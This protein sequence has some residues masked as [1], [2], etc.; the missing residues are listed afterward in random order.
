VG[1]GDPFDFVGEDG[2]DV[3]V[4]CI[5]GFTG[6]PYEMRYLS[7][8]LARTG[9]TV[10]GILLPG[11]GT[12]VDDLE[13]TRWE[14]WAGAVEREVDAMSKRCRRVALVGQSLGGLLALHSASRRPDLAAVA[15]LAAPLWLD[16][17]SGRVARWLTGPLGSRIRRI[18]KFGG[19]DVRDRVARAENPS[20]PS[21]PV[22]ALGELLAFMPIVEAALPQIVAPVLVLHARRDHTAP[23]G[24]AA[25]IIARAIRARARH[26]RILDRSFHLIAIDVERDLV[27]EEVI[28]FV[29][30]YAVTPAGTAGAPG[31]STCVM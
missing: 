23:V 16:G 8:A 21:I 29:R 25:R 17:L 15:S 19:A 26:T 31:D 2:G 18:P 7:T 6:S 24:C 13:R 1:A 4:I 11:H 12:S 9:A 5:H 22:R 10:R 14:D 28:A 30:R 3:G 27:A 20:Y